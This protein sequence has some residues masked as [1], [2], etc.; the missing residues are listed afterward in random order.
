M[1][2]QKPV[3]GIS[4]GDLNGIGPE[5][6]L[7]TFSDPR[8]LEHCTP[9]IFA[10]N[11]AINFYRKSFPD[12]NFNY[13]IIKDFSKINYR[14]INVFNCWEEEVAINPG[15]LTPTGGKYAIQSLIAAAEAARA[16]SKPAPAKPR[17]K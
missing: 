1:N 16:I 5:L 7:K 12:L 3:I 14:Q 10:S 6:I 9:I 17:R 15:Q 4:I 8:I 13:Q 2:Q 11:K